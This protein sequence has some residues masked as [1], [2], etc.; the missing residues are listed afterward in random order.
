MNQLDARV[1]YTQMVIEKIFLEML[2]EKPVIKITVTELCQRAQINRATFYKHYL[3]VPDL[4][5]KLEQRL[6][7]QIRTAFSDHATGMEAFLEDMLNYMRQEGMRFMILG[8]D[9]G[10]PNLVAKTFD[11][12]YENAYPILKINLPWLCDEE[13]QMLYH[14]V[15]QGSS[16]ILTYWVRN[17]MKQSPVDVIRFLM[18][19]C[20]AAIAPFDH[21]HD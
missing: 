16:G 6:F 11:V 13:R 4:L 12:C 17:G 10:D 5:E 19:V 15:S 20:A 7:E 18:K 21:P 3:D 9:H 14:F 2:V 1:R 8:S